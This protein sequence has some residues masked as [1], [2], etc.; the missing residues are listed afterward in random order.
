VFLSNNWFGLA[1]FTGLVAELVLVNKG[2][3]QGY[4]LANGLPVV[5]A[6]KRVKFLQESC[7]SFIN[8]TPN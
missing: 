8:M 5:F 7:A 6:L 3:W 4:Y 1:V 2:A